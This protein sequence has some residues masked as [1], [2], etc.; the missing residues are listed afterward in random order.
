MNTRY[1]QRCNRLRFEKGLISCA[2]ILQ[3]GSFGWSLT[4][5]KGISKYLVFRNKTVTDSPC[6]LEKGCKVVVKGEELDLPV[7][8]TINLVVRF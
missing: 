5:L 4:G 6:T 2:P 8:V 3:K 7:N 1:T